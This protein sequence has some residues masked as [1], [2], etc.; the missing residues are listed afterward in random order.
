MKSHSVKWV[1]DVK[2]RKIFIYILLKN[3]CTVLIDFPSFNVIPRDKVTSLCPDLK[4]NNKK[5]II[6]SSIAL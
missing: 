4:I 6:I 5:I 1:S 3:R 2:C